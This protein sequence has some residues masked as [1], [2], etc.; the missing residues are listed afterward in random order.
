M[1]PV[2]THTL[3]LELAGDCITREPFYARYPELIQTVTGIASSPW[4]PPCG[5]ALSLAQSR[6][7]IGSLFNP[8]ALKDYRKFR[9]TIPIVR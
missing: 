2:F 8:I 7:I 4:I 6:Q 5:H 1:E 9:G 3:G